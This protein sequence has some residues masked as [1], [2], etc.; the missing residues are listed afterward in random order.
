MNIKKDD[1]CKIKFNLQSNSTL[2]IINKFKV[3]D[4]QDFTSTP[5]TIKNINNTT[6]NKTRL[7]TLFRVKFVKMYLPDLKDVYIN[8]DM[9]LKCEMI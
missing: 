2:N 7:F 1:S 4:I 6:D 8:G 3:K 5:K 9:P